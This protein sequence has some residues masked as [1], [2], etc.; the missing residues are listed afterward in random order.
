MLIT[1]R[2][3]I[4]ERFPPGP[5]R[6][7]WLTWL[8]ATA[9]RD[10]ADV[11]LGGFTYRLFLTVASVGGSTQSCSASYESRRSVRPATRRLRSVSSG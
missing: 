4:Y 9:C 1:L 11:M 8:D 5:E 3:A 10:P 2:R 7:R 6:E